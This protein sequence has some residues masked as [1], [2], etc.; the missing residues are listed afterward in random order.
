M[1]EPDYA[2]YHTFLTR[3]IFRRPRLTTLEAAASG[4]DLGIRV[5][6]DSATS[7]SRSGS[8]GADDVATSLCDVRRL[9]A[10]TRLTVN[11][12]RGLQGAI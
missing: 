2:R 7:R 3:S 12:Q 5:V 10:I 11:A 9:A 8:E 6:K 1:L 4:N